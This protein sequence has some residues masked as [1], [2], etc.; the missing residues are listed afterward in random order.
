M[1]WHYMHQAKMKKQ[2]FIKNKV[3][4]QLVVASVDKVSW[5]HTSMWFH[6][7]L[8]GMMVM[9]FGE[10][11][12]NTILVLLTR[13]MPLSS[14]MQIALTNGHCETTFVN[15]KLLFY[16]CVPTLQH[17]ISLSI[18]ARIMEFTMVVWNACLLTWH[19]YNW[20][21]VCSMM[22]IATK[23]WSMRSTLL[24]L[25][26]LWPWMK[27]VVLIMSIYWKVHPHPWIGP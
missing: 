17:I 11:E 25:G 19:T 1:A 4:A 27:I 12:A 3:M 16:W 15:I 18:A 13:S 8:R 10:C 26:G 24:T 23:I 20:M 9:V 5:F 7:P 14:N 6:P 22:K 21:M 2:G